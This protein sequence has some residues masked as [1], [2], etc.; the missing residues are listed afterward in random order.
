MT[1]YQIVTTLGYGDAVGNDIIALMLALKRQGY[2]TKVFAEVIDERIDLDGVENLSTM[3]D[4]RKNDIILYHLATGAALN[5]NIVKYSCRKI[6]CYHNITPPYFFR[7][8]NEQAAMNCEKGLEGVAFLKD[9]VDYCLL[10]SEYNKRD[11]VKIGYKCKMD[12]L[13]I[14][15]QYDEYQKQPSK[16]IMAQMKDGMENI[17]FVGR[18]VPNK[19]QENVIAA[20]AMYKKYYNP[21]ARLILAGSYNGME[22]YYNCLKVYVEQ[23]EIHDVVFTGH[24]QFEELLAYYRCAHMFLCMSEHE[25]FCVPL[26]EAMYFDV[27]VIAY[28]SDTAVGE[29]LKGAGILMENKDPLETAACMNRLSKDNQLKNMI[30]HNQQKRLHDFSEDKILKTFLEYIKIFIGD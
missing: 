18:I 4:I 12:V 5:F 7:P 2:Q 13:P 16:Q 17:L 29:T 22:E 21:N 27:P 10:D 24:I 6:L 28:D 15:L 1:I 11:L 14:L 20:F 3:P 30:L 25:G 8:Y 26:V 19:K 9:K 23:N